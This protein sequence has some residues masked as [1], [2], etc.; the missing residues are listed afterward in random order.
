MSSYKINIKNL[1]LEWNIK[2]NK[3][4]AIV[5]DNGANIVKAVHDFAGR[6]KHL[7]CFAHTFNLVVEKAISETAGFKALITKVKII[8]TYFKQRVHANDE[9][10]K[11]QKNNDSG[12]Q[13]LVQDV[14]TRWNST[15]YMLERFV[16]LS[17]LI[18]AILLQNPKA[19]SM[20]TGG[21]LTTK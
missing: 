14:S 13:K 16:H 10:R 15:F 18:S 2:V 6:K 1:C 21:R 8:V 19:P 12:V 9:L 3:I 5:T 4:F 20:L 17:G 11:L 7:P